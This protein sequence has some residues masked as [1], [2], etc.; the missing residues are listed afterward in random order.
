ME[1]L[2]FHLLGDPPFSE[3]SLRRILTSYF[4]YYGLGLSTEP[5]PAGCKKLKGPNKRFRLRIAGDY[6]V[7][8]SL[9]KEERRIVIEL[10]GHRK[11]AYR[12]L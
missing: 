9:F 2:R 4:Q 12:W 7:V 3:A 11:D 5:F 8:Y 1:A 6:R 10:A